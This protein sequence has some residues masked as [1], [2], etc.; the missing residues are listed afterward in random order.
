MR[1]N[2]T[3]N[4]TNAGLFEEVGTSGF[5]SGHVWLAEGSF[6]P[7]AACA[8]DAGLIVVAAPNHVSNLQIACHPAGDISPWAGNDNNPCKPSF[9]ATI[10][11]SVP[12]TNVAARID[13]MLGG[14]TS[15]FFPLEARSFAC[16]NHDGGCKEKNCNV[17]VEQHW[18]KVPMRHSSSTRTLR[19]L[20][21]GLR[22]SGLCRSVQ[23]LIVSVLRTP[24]F[25]ATRSACKVQDS[26][27]L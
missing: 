20:L 6:S 11:V 23:W 4:S 17:S 7:Q 16:R 18:V 9:P 12:G 26:D 25:C 10:R 19:D 1:T 24:Q 15:G 3:G 13:A 22:P 8:M 21:S 5:G 2:P 27:T 14:S